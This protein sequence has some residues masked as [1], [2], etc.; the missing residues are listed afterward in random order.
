MRRDICFIDSFTGNAAHL[1]RGKR[2]PENVLEAL[3]HDPRVSTWERR[4]NISNPAGGTRRS[5]KFT[6]WQRKLKK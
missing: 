2:T 1:P 6:I 5:G 3:R 4:A